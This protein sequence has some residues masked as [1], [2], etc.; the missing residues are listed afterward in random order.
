MAWHV[1]YIPADFAAIVIG[2]REAEDCRES[3]KMIDH[4]REILR[5]LRRKKTRLPNPEMLARWRRSLKSFKKH[6]KRSK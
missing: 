4:G 6:C 1:D 5:Q 3:G 2:L